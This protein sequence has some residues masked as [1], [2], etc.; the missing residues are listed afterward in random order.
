MSAKEIII[1]AVIIL[2]G[3]WVFYRL[4]EIHGKLIKLRRDSESIYRDTK[5]ASRINTS[6]GT[7]GYNTHHEIDIESM[8]EIRADYN[9]HGADYQSLVQLISIFP[10]LGLFGTVL[11][12]MPGL[13]AVLNEDFTTLYASLSTAL[14]STL[15]GLIVAIALKFYVAV[16]PSRTIYEIESNLAE[17][18]RAYDYALGFRK[19]EEE[20]DQ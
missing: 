20:K 3:I 17:N 18:D 15:C 7:L 6:S 4:T 12:L 2:L 16:R 1:D 14:S 9:R 5:S 13:K 19:L 11:G 8:N 10:L